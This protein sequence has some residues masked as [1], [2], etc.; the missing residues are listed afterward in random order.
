MSIK[1]ELD[2]CSVHSFTMFN[3]EREANCIDPKYKYIW[4]KITQQETAAKEHDFEYKN[5]QSNKVVHNYGKHVNYQKPQ[6][7]TEGDNQCSTGQ[8]IR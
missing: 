4:K 3:S 2:K 8:P 6:K 1:R 7:Y 5:L